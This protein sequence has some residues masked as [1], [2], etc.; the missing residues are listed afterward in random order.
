[1]IRCS[2]VALGVLVCASIGIADDAAK[3][4]TFTK[5]VAPIFFANCINCHR[6]G[7]IGPMSMSSYSDVR[8]WVK[9]IRSQVV[10][11]KMPPW[12]A[13][14]RYGKFSNDISLSDKDIKT[15]SDWVDAGA[16][17]GDP[18]LMPALP[19]APPE[20]ELGPPDYIVELPEFKVPATGPDEFP[21]LV[22]ELD[23]PDDKWLRAIEYKPGNPKVTHHMVL[24]AGEGGMTGGG[25]QDGLG[26][27]A[28]SGWAVGT[29]PVLY[30]EGIG[31]EI[32]KHAKM[33]VNMHYHPS[34]EAQTDKTRIGFYFGKGEIRKV[35][36]AIAPLSLALEIPPN[37][38]DYVS[39]GNYLAEQD[40]YAYMYFPHMHTRGK[41]M[42][43]TAHFPDGRTEIL[44]SVPTYDFNWQWNYYLK[45]PLL[46]PQGTIIEVEGHHDNT[47]NNPN[48]P[49]PSKWLRFGEGSH[50]EMMIGAIAVYPAEGIRMNSP[51]LMG[52]LD[53]FLAKNETDSLYRVKVPLGNLNP[54]MLLDLPES[55]KARWLIAIPGQVVWVAPA[56]VEWKDKS[57]SFRL[58]MG[59]QLGKITISGTM[60]DDGVIVNG[61]MLA[62]NVFGAA[63]DRGTRNVP[64][65]AEPVKKSKITEKTVSQN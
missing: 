1:M 47:A 23:I 49:D 17:E 36:A 10:S 6:D 32:G 19:P 27:G 46:I 61:K 45:E 25:S 63:G 55:G 64:F 29:P 20:W 24:Y 34:G 53:D 12:Q 51:D 28:F 9:S 26:G 60:R 4:P 48:N 14:L 5:D 41:A 65:I 44:L 57:F 50:D 39:R 52:R 58:P 21:N 30:P 3:S 35:T 31:F 37:D 54:P 42:K 62:E 38:P 40:L 8:P 2:L 33:T 13:D 7:Q 59:E 15:I 56:E 22:A 11:R 16:P 18:S 43:Y